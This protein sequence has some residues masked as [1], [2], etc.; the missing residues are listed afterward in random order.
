MPPED[1]AQS[2]QIEADVLGRVQGVGFRYFVQ[3]AARRLQ[4]T[5]W[6]RNNSDGSVSVL[7]EGDVPQLSKLVHALQHGPSLARVE[8]VRFRWNEASGRYTEFKIE[9]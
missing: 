9:Q 4:V 3:T 8:K 5:G 2:Q 6:V 7:A 1:H